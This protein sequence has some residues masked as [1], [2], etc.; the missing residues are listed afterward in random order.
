MKTSPIETKSITSDEI[1]QLIDYDHVHLQLAMN[2][3]GLSKEELAPPL[4]HNEI[5]QAYNRKD[6]LKWILFDKQLA[7]YFWFQIKS[8]CLYINAIAIDKKFQGKGIVQYVLTLADKIAG[9]HLSRCSLSVSP[10]NGRALNAYLK[11]GY[12]IVDA[13]SSFFGHHYPNTF[14]LVMEKSQLNG[15]KKII[16]EF[17]VSCINYEKLKNTISSG[18]IGVGLIVSESGRNDQNMIHFVKCDTAD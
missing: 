16:D 5:I 8:D 11:F 4:T 18:Y 12:Q 14:R 9:E 15:K 13:V 7:G 2:Q 17:D 6:I 10:M 3:S 1:T